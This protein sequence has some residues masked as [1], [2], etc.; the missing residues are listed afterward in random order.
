MLVLL[1]FTELVSRCFI[2]IWIN[3][4]ITYSVLS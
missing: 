4:V 2:E 3:Q 1:L